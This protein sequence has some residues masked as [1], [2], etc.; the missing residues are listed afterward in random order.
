MNKK[1]L[2][3]ALIIILVILGAVYYVNNYMKQTKTGPLL[4]IGTY[5]ENA[6]YQIDRDL[7][8]LRNGVSETQIPNSSTIVIT[9][10]FGEHIYGDLNGDGVDDAGLILQYEPGGSGT[11]YYAASAINNN[12]NFQGTNAILL[13][14]RIAPQNI[15]IR[16]GILIANYAERKTT[17]PMT[18]QP[19]IGVSKYMRFDGGVLKE[20][21][22]PENL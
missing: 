14:D 18:T 4:Q 3:I 17:D 22:K 5:P 11:F 2:L 7:V 12:G 6:S 1:I 13:G 20:I 9:R 16:D 10:I 19:S 15:Q 21:S 8:T